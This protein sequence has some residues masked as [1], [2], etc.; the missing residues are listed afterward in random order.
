MAHRLSIRSLFAATLALLVVAVAALAGGCTD[1]KSRFQD[2]D[3]RVPQTPVPD[4]GPDAMPLDMLPDVTGEFL[5]AFAINIQRSTPIQFRME[6]VLTMNG[7]GTGTLDTVITPLTV[8][9]RVPVGD[10]L[11]ANGVPV[12]ITGE[13]VI[14]TNDVHIP[15]AANPITGSDIVADTIMTGTLKSPDRLCGIL[16]GMVS[17]PLVL[18]LDPNSSFGAIRVTPGATGAELPEPE[19]ECPVELPD[20]G[21]PDAGAADAGAADAA[22]PDAGA[23][24]A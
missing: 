2:F 12:A 20:G 17:E 18:N 11:I 19:V 24:D 13:F 22:I 21:V 14:A 15:G 10:P 6:N 3:D 4:G 16:T 7:D 1:P 5:L 8:G 9:T 23:P